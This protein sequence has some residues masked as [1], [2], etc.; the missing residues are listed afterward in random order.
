MLVDDTVKEIKYSAD[1]HHSELQW[2]SLIWGASSKGLKYGEQWS[3]K[4]IK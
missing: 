2:T 4:A 3:M 1:D